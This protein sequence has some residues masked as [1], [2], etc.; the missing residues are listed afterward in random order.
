MGNPTACIT[1]TATRKGTAHDHYHVSHVP[2]C[3]H[4]AQPE[5]TQV[6]NLPRLQRKAPITTRDTNHAQ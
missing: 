6:G 1:L 3:R 2:G 5:N 4:R